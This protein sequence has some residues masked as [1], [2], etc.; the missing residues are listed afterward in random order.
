GKIG[1]VVEPDS[2]KIADVLVDFYENNRMAE[3]EANVVDEKKKFSWSNMVNSFLYLY[4]TMKST[5]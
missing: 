2:E 4:K 3:F 5:K 1:Y